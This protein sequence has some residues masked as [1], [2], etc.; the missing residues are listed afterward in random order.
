MAQWVLGHFRIER[1]SLVERSAYNTQKKAEELGAT[2]R[3]WKKFSEV[4]RRGKLMTERVAL[5]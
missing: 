1:F 2:I 5:G 4:K 3:E